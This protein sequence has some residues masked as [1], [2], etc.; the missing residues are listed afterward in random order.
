MQ[1]NGYLYMHVILEISWPITFPLP[2]LTSD[3][4]N[5]NPAHVI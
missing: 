2:L 3:V 1:P 5:N 4:F